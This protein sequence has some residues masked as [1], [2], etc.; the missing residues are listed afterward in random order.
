M[1]DRYPDD[2]LKNI[3][4]LTL[5]CL[6]ATRVQHSKEQQSLRFLFIN[7]LQAVSRKHLFMAPVH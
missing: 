2:E 1:F 5:L 7:D 4:L 6:L 3:I